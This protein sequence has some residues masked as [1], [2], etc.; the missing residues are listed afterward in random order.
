MD[1]SAAERT[2]PGRR[3]LILAGRALEYGVTRSRRRTVSIIVGPD[4]LAVRAPHTAPWHA[5][6]GFLLA[7]AHWIVTRLD[8]WRDAPRPARIIGISGET[9]PVMGELLRL[10]VRGAKPGVIREPGVLVVALREP[11]DQAAARLALVKWLKRTG[12]E[13]FAPRAADFAARLGI[14]APPVTV[15]CA[16]ARWGSCSVEGRIRLAWRLV[17]L[18]P[19]HSDYV[20]AHEVAHVVQPDHSPRFWSVLE[21]LYPDSRNARRELGRAAA[22]IPLIEGL[23]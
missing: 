4:G 19:H 22:T 14:K 13:A 18:A 6:E 20:I 2:L 7:K 1:R 17:H 16:R 12:L 9:L 3:R 23:P 15:S 8:A 21:S 5:I 11:L 10:E